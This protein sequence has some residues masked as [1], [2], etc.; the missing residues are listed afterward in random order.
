M[1]QKKCP[2]KIDISDINSVYNELMKSNY[3]NQN[4]SKFINYNE[5]VNK[6]LEFSEKPKKVKKGKKS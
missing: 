6:I 1:K 2:D 5:A 4:R 3:I